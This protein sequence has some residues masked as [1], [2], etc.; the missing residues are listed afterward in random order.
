MSINGIPQ[1]K[2]NEFISIKNLRDFE[3][4][5]ASVIEQDGVILLTATGIHRRAKRPP[6]KKFQKKAFDYKILSDLIDDSEDVEAMDLKTIACVVD[7]H[8]PPEAVCVEVKMSPHKR[9]EY[10]VS[11]QDCFVGPRFN[12]ERVLPAEQMSYVDAFAKKPIS[13]DVYSS[14]LLASDAEPWMVNSQKDLSDNT[15]GFGGLR[16]GLRKVGKVFVRPVELTREK[17]AEESI[18]D[19]TEE[20][21]P[22]EPVLQRIKV[23]SFILAFL[24]LAFVAVV[25]AFALT[26]YKTFAGQTDAIGRKSNEAIGA[27]SLMQTDKDLNISI[28]QLEMASSKFREASMMLDESRLLA[29]SA[30]AV[31]PDKYRGAKALLEVGEK[32][33]EAGKILSLGF[34]KVFDDEKRPL[35]ER[36]EVLGA[37]ADAVLPMLL[38]AEKAS[39]GVDAKQ[40]PSE[41]QNAVESLPLQLAEAKHTVRELKLVS[42]ALVGFLGKGELRN[43]LLVFQNDSELRPSGGFMGSIAEVRLLNGE[44]HSIYV[45]PGGPYDLKSQLTARVQSPGPMHLI[46]PLWQF[47]DA[48][49]FGDFYKSAQKVNWFWSKSGQPT[50]DGVIAVNASFMED[51]LKVT[52]P[53]E[54]QEYGKTI[55]AENFYLETQKVVELEYDKEENKPKK[56]I[57][58]M[59]DK[60][61]LR[62]KDLSRDD[63]LKLA[64]AASEG[65]STKDIQVA[66]FNPEEQDFVEKF[67]W[68]GS[69][70]ETNG[71]FLAIVEANIAGQKTDRVVKE[72]VLHEVNIDAKGN[73]TNKVLLNRVHE[74][75]KNELFYGVRNVSY[76]RFYIPKGSELISA[77]GFLPPPENLFKKPLDTDSL[78]PDIAVVE[79]SMVAGPGTVSV[80][81]EDGYT[82]VGGWLQLDPGRSQDVTITYALPFTIRDILTSLDN[83]MPEPS[84]NEQVRAAYLMLYTSQSGKP[85]ELTQKINV[86]PSWSIAWDRS[87]L[88][89]ASDKED[90]LNKDFT[91]E[92]LWDRDKVSAMLFNLK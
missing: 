31:A 84:S 3:S 62:V 27:L 33:S 55:T 46:N 19:F 49:W 72:S 75:N 37:H 12:E 48:N 54:M 65:L 57:G 77:E 41:Y 20:E 34:S 70:K 10:V 60:L 2:D 43:Y 7:S 47:Q 59:F 14:T 67:G 82:V 73:I 81:M 39:L 69:F 83:D 30:A 68:G 91:H 61:L 87:D 64:A 21:V 89:I 52:G 71:D 17:V 50:V 36:I 5:L 78:D 26:T 1:S 23:K 9:S 38:D 25:P 63:W 16:R 85:R 66:M 92:M 6:K 18:N 44:L 80:S 4:P 22:R 8:E 58:D 88:N 90:T 28:N 53:I 86:D 79:D 29:L 45:P 24:G 15:S 51:I 11:L 42:E 76:V 35:I 56:F 32:T 74:G 13:P 40:M